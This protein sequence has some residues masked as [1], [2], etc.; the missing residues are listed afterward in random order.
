MIRGLIGAST[1]AI[2]GNGPTENSAAKS[3]AQSA[4]QRS[5]HEHPKN[6]E[7]SGRGQI[8]GAPFDSRSLRSGA[9]PREVLVEIV[10]SGGIFAPLRDALLTRGDYYMHL[11][12]LTSFLEADRWLYDLYTDAVAWSPKAI[13]NVTGSGKFS[14]DRTIAEYA[15]EIWNAKAAPCPDSPGERED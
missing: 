2:V 5:T 3:K 4:N 13:L 7:S 11:A 6:N 14:S 12:D 1:T 15:S 8:P 9:Q 10:A